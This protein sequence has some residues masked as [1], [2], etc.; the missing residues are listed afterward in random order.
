MKS[1]ILFTVRLHLWFTNWNLFYVG[2]TK[3]C[4]QDKVSEHKKT[5]NDNYPMACHFKDKHNS[6]PSI[7]R[8]ISIE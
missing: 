8:A 7:L 4:L 5:K 2:R 6:D 1:N 3:R